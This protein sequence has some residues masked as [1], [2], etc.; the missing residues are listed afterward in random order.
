M[1]RDKGRS[2][3]SAHPESMRGPLPDVRFFAGMDSLIVSPYF[4]AYL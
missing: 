2:R 4:L 1:T 3:C